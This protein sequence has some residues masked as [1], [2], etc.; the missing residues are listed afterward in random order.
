MDVHEELLRGPRGRRWCVNC[1]SDVD[2]A[3]AT[4]LFWLARERDPHPGTVLRF[5]SDE[6]DALGDPSFTDIE[7]ASFIENAD[8]VGVTSTI[9]RAALAS[10]VDLARYWQEPDGTDVVA[11]LPVVRASLSTVARRLVALMPELT[12][13]AAVQQWTVQWCRVSESAAIQRDAA[14]ALAR[15]TKE[16][17]EDERRAARER[18]ADPHANWSGT[19]WSVPQQLLSSRGTPLAALDM[20]EDPMGW[21]V[22]TVVPVAGR[23]AVLE[24]RS[25]EDWARLCREYPM[26]VTASRRHD[27]FRVTGRDGRWL[28][29][30]WERVAQHWDAIHLTTLGYLSAATCLIPIDEE[31]ASVIAGWGPDSTIWLTDSARETDGPREQWER[32]ANSAQWTVADAAS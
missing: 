28:I 8:A 25:P 9:A 16:Q 3:T 22:A 32:A 24:I 31:Y 20:V 19:W 14:S 26:E 4:A 27:W 15:W 13:S 21:T 10:S 2:E 18:P 29:P 7:L 17:R 12:A 5:G 30:D 6:N 23:G 11:A 1:V